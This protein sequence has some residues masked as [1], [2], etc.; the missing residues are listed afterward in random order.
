MGKSRITR[1]NK[2]ETVKNR[3]DKGEIQEKLG[4]TKGKLRLERTGKGESQVKP[5]QTRGEI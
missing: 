5:G 1:I 3:A 2:G 4:R